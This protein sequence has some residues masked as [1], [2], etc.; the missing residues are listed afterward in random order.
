MAA[1]KKYLK[2]APKSL[3]DIIG[4]ADIFLG[5]SAGGVLKPDMVKQMGERPLILAGQVG[6]CETQALEEL[7]VET[8][9]DGADGHVFAIAGFKT[10]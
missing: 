3:G 10:V 2:A 9:L 6:C 1:I 4:G 8:L 5:L 7:G